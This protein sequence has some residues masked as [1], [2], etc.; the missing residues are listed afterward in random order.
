M[1]FLSFNSW[2]SFWPLTYVKRSESKSMFS[3]KLSNLD[4][5]L[6]SIE[7]SWNINEKFQIN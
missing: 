4:N 7:I 3:S 1:H 5:Y 2:F 6:I